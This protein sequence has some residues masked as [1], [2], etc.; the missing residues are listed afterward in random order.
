MGGKLRWPKVL[1]RSNK[2]LSRLGRNAEEVRTPGLHKNIPMGLPLAWEGRALH[3]PHLGATSSEGIPSFWRDMLRNVLS[4]QIHQPFYRLSFRSRRRN[5]YT[6]QR[7]DGDRGVR[8]KQIECE[9]LNC[10]VRIGMMGV[11]L[12]RE[13]RC[14]PK[15]P[16]RRHFAC[17]VG[18][19]DEYPQYSG[20]F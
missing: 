13:S 6:G 17:L 16:L 11:T 4:T 19:Y 7:H 14:R 15:S 1:P 12:L 9:M 20:S 18:R 3:F 8:W 2:L 5:V 10:A